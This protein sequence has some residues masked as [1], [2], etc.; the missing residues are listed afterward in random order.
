MVDANCTFDEIEAM[1]RGR[2]YEELG[3]YWFEEPMQPYMRDSHARLAA[4]LD[5]PIAIGENY[6]TRHH[7]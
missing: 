7:N 6:Y 1:R 4:A 3:I 2:A 5:L